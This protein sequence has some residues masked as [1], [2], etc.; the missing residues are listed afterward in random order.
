MA[1]G[2]TAASATA[3][4]FNATQIKAIKDVADIAVRCTEA[5]K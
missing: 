4:I 1:I 2:A 3:T 5:L